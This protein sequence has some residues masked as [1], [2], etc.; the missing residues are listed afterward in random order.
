MHLSRSR[1]L[2]INPWVQ[3][4]GM[5]VQEIVDRVLV[6]AAGLRPARNLERVSG[7][8]GTKQLATLIG[9]LFHHPPDSESAAYPGMRF[10]LNGIFRYANRQHMMIAAL[11]ARVREALKQEQTLYGL[12]QKAG[13]HR[14]TLYG[15][16]RPDWNPTLGTVEKLS[17]FLPDVQQDAAA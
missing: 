8:E 1:Q 11:Q 13:L 15:W 17:P 7:D 3:C 9:R 2:C 5:A 16:D 10:R 12:C 4:L 6:H 14:N